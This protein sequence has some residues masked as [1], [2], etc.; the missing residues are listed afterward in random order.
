MKRGAKENCLNHRPSKYTYNCSPESESDADT[1]RS[2]LHTRPFLQLPL[3]E[4]PQP[5]ERP[6][7]IFLQSQSQ[8][9]SQNQS[10]MPMQM[11]TPANDKTDSKGKQRAE[12]TCVAGV[13]EVC[14]WANV[15]GSGSCS[16]FKGGPAGTKKWKSRGCSQSTFQEPAQSKAQAHNWDDSEGREGG[17]DRVAQGNDD[18]QRVYEAQ[19]EQLCVEKQK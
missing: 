12:R 8:S 19:I 4:L 6:P 18:K 10:R 9:Q 1:D 15:S 5:A 14:Q 16:K 17:R 11:R 2:S 7:R 13:H 3:R